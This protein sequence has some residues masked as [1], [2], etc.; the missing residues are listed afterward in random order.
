M[1]RRL[2]S[3]DGQSILIDRYSSMYNSTNG[4]HDRPI[5]ELLQYKHATTQR[6]QLP[7]S[8]RQQISKEVE[9][10]SLR[11]N[12]HTKETREAG[13]AAPTAMDAVHIMEKI[14]TGLLMDRSMIRTMIWWGELEIVFRTPASSLS[15]SLSS[16]F[17]FFSSSSSSSSSCILILINPHSY[18]HPHHDPNKYGD[19]H[20]YVSIRR[21]GAAIYW[22]F[23]W[24]SCVS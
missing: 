1:Y 11:R 19:I 2:V 5:H 4:H 8:I 14:D 13:A 17:F 24:T 22:Y 12:V 23:I 3:N 9:V 20:I 15:L 10:E 18:S 21:Y 16:F 7:L 6:M